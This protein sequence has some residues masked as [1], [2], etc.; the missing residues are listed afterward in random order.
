MLDPSE[1]VIGKKYRTRAFQTVTYLGMR[2]GHRVFYSHFKEEI[3]FITSD[4]WGKN[5]FN[6]SDDIYEKLED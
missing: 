2:K 3:E 6:A 1:F 4:L 5:E